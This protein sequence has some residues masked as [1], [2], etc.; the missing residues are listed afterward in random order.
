MRFLKLF[1]G[2]IGLAILVSNIW[3]ISRWNESRG[4]YD[5]I[6][7]LR[8]AHL[9]QR[10]GIDG[11]NTDVARDDD[12]YL[13]TKLKEI[14]YPK[15][16]EPAQAPCHS[17]QPSVQK[18]VLTP[19]PGT[20]F[21]L[22]IFPSGFQVIPL[23]ISAN[24]IVFGF[25]LFALFYAR[26]RADI[27]LSGIF[28]CIALYL[29][30]NPTKASY[31]LAP[32]T[33]VC[34]LAAFFTAKFPLAETA[35][36]R[37]LLAVS[38][39][40]LIGLSVNFRIANLF[41]AGGFGIYLLGLFILKRSFE[42]LLQGLLFG[43]ACLVGMT[44]TLLANAINA[45]SPLATTYDGPDVGAPTF[46]LP[47]IWQYLTDMQCVL[48]VLAIGWMALIFYGRRESAIRQTALFTAMNLVINL[49]FF[50]SHAIFTPYY[51]LPI[52]VLSLWSLL[53]AT[54]V[55]P[56]TEVHGSGQSKRSVVST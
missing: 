49:T 20:G 46:S 52:A 34:V 45:G 28:G 25:V 12:H 40:F 41:L 56:T 11:L 37:F 1:F 48:I 9:F 8:Q 29:M 7:Y 10:F 3:T 22:A 24:L 26:T 32:S 42:T 16:N 35:T 50:M 19:P 5:D 31:S 14:G 18:R 51:L 30:I 13:A 54:L 4:V 36:R 2:L 27:L 17:L 53:F 15:W 23:Y 39:G 44:P 55:Q 21:V 33:V 6:C 43:A 47:V 38:V